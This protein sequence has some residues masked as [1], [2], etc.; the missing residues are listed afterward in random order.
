MPPAKP[1]KKTAGASKRRATRQK[2]SQ[3]SVP[4]VVGIGVSER[5]LDDLHQLLQT[6]PSQSGLAFVLIPHPDPAYH[7]SPELI[8]EWTRM[9]VTEARQDEPLLP[10][11]VYSV[12]PNKFP[13]IKN[14]M[15]QLNEFK[16]RPG[17][18]LPIDY[19]VDSPEKDSNANAI[20]I[21]MSETGADD[22][23]LINLLS[24]VDLAMLCLDRQLRIKWITP[25]MQ[26]LFG[27]RPSDVDRPVSEFPEALSG[28]G[29]VSD[30]QRVM[31]EQLVITKEVKLP[32]GHWYLRR[33]LPYRNAQGNVTGIAISIIDIHE[34]KQYTESLLENQKNMAS[35]LEQRVQERTRQLRE[36]SVQLTLAEERERRTLARDL[37]DDLGQLL[38]VAKI[39]VSALEKMEKQEDF[40]ERIHEINSILEQ[41]HDSVHSLTFQLNPP[42]LDELGLVAALEWLGDEMQRH[43]GLQV[44]FSDDG[45][46]KDLDTPVKTILFR[47][48]RELLINVAKHAD[49]SSA[50]VTS[51]RLNGQISIQV[52]DQGIGFEHQVHH[53]SVNLTNGGFGLLSVRERLSYIGGEMRVKSIPGDGTQVTLLAPLSG[54]T[55]DVRS[56]R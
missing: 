40:R 27:L 14:G 38:A 10:N 26:L 8:A 52:E 36:L 22:T 50:S 46:P 29:L 47:A 19:F 51:K 33:L 4:R 55:K 20:G 41:A 45:K 17:L 49:V 12:P 44:T 39:K 31:E 21:V 7:L 1:A 2:R 9:P 48:V 11:H 23:D 18:Q 3:V 53:Q 35:S 37:H 34:T 5:S 25:G 43:Y 42:I 6:I 54:Q 32:D 30:A 15:L 13:A 56:P 24:S 28:E 16:P